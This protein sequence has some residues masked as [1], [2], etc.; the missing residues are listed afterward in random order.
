VST[1]IKKII[2][3]TSY[4]LLL[5]AFLLTAYILNYGITFNDI[6]A[7][8]LS[9]SFSLNEKLAFVRKNKNKPEV[10]ALGSSIC[11][12]NIHSETVI[13]RLHTDRYLNASSWGMTMQDNYSI[14]KLLC[15]IHMPRTLILSSNI[16]EF[17]LPA[18]KMNFSVLRDYLVSSDLISGFYYVR[19]FD[20]RYYIENIK[21]A[22]KVRT[23][24]NEYEY[25]L[26]DDF[27]GI[28]LE[29]KD[30]KIN[31]KRWET[32]FEYGKILDKNYSYLDSI[33]SFCKFN[34][35][36]LLFFQSPFRAGL[37]SAFDDRKMGELKT[38]MNKIERIVKKNGQIF[39]NPTSVSWNDSL[40]VD[41]EHLNARG[42]QLFTDFCFNNAE[43]I[44]R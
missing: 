4:C 31:P 42:A 39:I 41:G 12:N 10:I 3:F 9:D 24:K 23:C 25:L 15:A 13:E 40:F 11:L 16:S 35:I 44:K 7:P 20:L 33:S 14:L 29:G 28:N 6:P 26:F 21:Y 38:H 30:F 2:L 34:D 22:K 36:Q 19:C 43:N 1:L 5:S 8:H 32:D 17:Q 18:K 37:S 27:G